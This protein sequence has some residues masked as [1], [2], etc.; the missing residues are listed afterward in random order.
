MRAMYGHDLQNRANAVF[1]REYLDIKVNEFSG[2]T[3]YSQGGIQVKAIPVEHHDGNP[4]FG[5]RVDTNRG[6]VLM[7]G[8]ATLSAL[9]LN[10]GK[11]VDVLI[12]NVAA[13][14][15]KIEGSGTIDAVLAKL[16]RPEQAALLFK[17]TT[18]R[19]AVFSHIVKKRTTRH[20]E[21]HCRTSMDRRPGD[22]TRGA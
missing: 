8:D 21:P 13:G 14:S 10:A 12:S 19:L 17:G 11:G 5:Y 16:M 1:K 18:P 2:G 3:V 7:T 15:T 6:S 22:P 4:A 20:P 9:L